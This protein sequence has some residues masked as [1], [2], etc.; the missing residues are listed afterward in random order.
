MGLIFS[1]HLF[2]AK[3]SEDVQY[4][5]YFN[6]PDGGEAPIYGISSQIAVDRI[7]SCN[8]YKTPLKRITLPIY[9]NFIKEKVEV[10]ILLLNMYA[11]IYLMVQLKETLETSSY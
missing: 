10:Y 7:T 1:D 2:G 6:K 4:V 11:N 3:D 5:I 9:V 8:Q